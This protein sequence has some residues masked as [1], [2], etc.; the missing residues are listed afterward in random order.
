M[1]LY[2]IVYVCRMEYI[3]KHGVHYLVADR[4]TVA[5]EC[6]YEIYILFC[7]STRY[8]VYKSGL[9]RIM[10][11]L[12]WIT[13]Y[14]SQVRQFGNDIYNWWNDSWKSLLYKL[15]SDKKLLFMLTHTLFY[16]LQ[17]MSWT[18]KS[19]KNNYWLLTSQLS[20]RIVFFDPIL[21]CYQ[22]WYVMSRECE[23]LALWHHIQPLF[24]HMQIG[25]KVI[26]T[27]E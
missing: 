16:F 13:I 25:T 21:W 3:H 9:Y 8:V 22:S 24:C 10:Y 19:A 1:L 7:C 26:F 11:G 23:V 4:N 18:N 6:G 20:P 14:L 2:E 5:V 12:A 27:S 17:N 15:M